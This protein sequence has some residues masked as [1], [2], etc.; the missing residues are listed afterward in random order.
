[1]HAWYRDALIAVAVYPTYPLPPNTRPSELASRFTVGFL[2]LRRQRGLQALQAG[3]H[4]VAVLLQS[5]GPPGKDGAD[6]HQSIPTSCA[7][8]REASRLHSLS[9]EHG[10]C[11][12]IV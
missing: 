2:G 10:G 7:L 9:L 1:R 5:V 8:S 12:S 11:R 6:L 3:F 4:L